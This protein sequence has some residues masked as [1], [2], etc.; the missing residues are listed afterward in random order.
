[1]NRQHCVSEIAHS[2]HTR[3]QH[4]RRNRKLLGPGLAFILIASG[5]AVVRA[6]PFP[7]LFYPHAQLWQEQPEE[8]TWPVNGILRSNFGRRSDPLS[9]RR[10]FH[11]G[12][13]LEVPLGTPVHVTADG[14][15][16]DAKWSGAYGKLVKVDH[17]NG[18]ETYYA[19][20]STFLVL[21][22]QEVQRG[23]VIALSGRTG[24]VTGPHVHYEVRLRG[25]PVNPLKYLS[26]SQLLKNA[27]SE[28]GDTG[29]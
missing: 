7:P 23:E 6:A 28:H 10:R 9:G 20:L 18:V 11:T 2:M 3:F 12:V 1:M 21:P 25:T 5:F 15:V 24:R 13:D 19:H 17:G 16:T 22:G 26:N 8:S 29:F 4:K 27:L 14:I